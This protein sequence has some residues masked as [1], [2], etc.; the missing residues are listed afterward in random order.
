LIDSEAAS[1]GAS[2]IKVQSF[3]P[4]DKCKSY[5]HVVAGPTR[6]EFDVECSRH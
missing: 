3:L 4:D 1:K 6:A 2:V 5:L